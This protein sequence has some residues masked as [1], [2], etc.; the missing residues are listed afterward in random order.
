MYYLYLLG[1]KLALLLPRRVG[2]FLADILALFKFYLSRKD[3]E[4]LLNN[5]R[6]FIPDFRKRLVIVKEIFRNFAFYLVDFFR[7]AK[8]NR[9]FIKKYVRVEG[10]EYLEELLKRGEKIIAL[11][12]H[13]GNYE[14]GGALTSL[15]GFKIV[16]VALPHSDPRINNFFNQQ[17][18]VCGV[19]VVQTGMGIKRCF[20]VLEEGKIL[21]LLGDRDFSGKGRK[22]NMF[23]KICILPRGPAVFSLKTKSYILPSFLVRENSKK[24]FYRLIFE[25]PISPYK[26]GNKKSEEEMIGECARILE[27]YIRM[28]P[29][30]WYM[31]GRFWVD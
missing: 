16:A 19:E 3:K 30:Q 21:A 25:K 27:K 31:F 12:A 13:L 9:E 6:P 22:T 8:L 26:N 7:F 29:E 2:Y 17:R 11:T 1:R 5:L 24:L 15:L 10:L 18:N 28:Y 20:K 23:N 4:I 14:L